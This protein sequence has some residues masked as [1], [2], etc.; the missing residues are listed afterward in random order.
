MPLFPSTR[1]VKHIDI[2][3]PNIDTDICQIIL[4]LLMLHVNF[5]LPI[6][7]PQNIYVSEI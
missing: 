1:L 3:K 4:H 5:M 6:F 7:I 2:L